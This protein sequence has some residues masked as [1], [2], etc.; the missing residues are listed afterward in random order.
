MFASKVSND[1][2]RFPCQRDSVKT[3]FDQKNMLAL[4]L[5]FRNAD[6]IKGT[7]SF[8]ASKKE[9]KVGLRLLTSG[10]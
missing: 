5:A 7:G 10:Y 9:S 1:R 4:N 3:Q 6:V 8:S 2:K